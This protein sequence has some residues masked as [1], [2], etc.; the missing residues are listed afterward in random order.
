M[1]GDEGGCR[2]ITGNSIR[3]LDLYMLAAREE[4]EEQEEEDYPN[5]KD[6]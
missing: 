6:E 1:G 3:W 2:R 5:N 4:E